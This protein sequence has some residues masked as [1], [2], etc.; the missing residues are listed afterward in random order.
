MDASNEDG[1]RR[2]SWWQTLPG[3][4]TAVA[5]V[6][7][8]VAGLII[9]LNGRS[10]GDETSQESPVNLSPLPPREGA[11]SGIGAAPAATTRATTAAR[12]L[13]ARAFP[14]GTTL[15]LSGGNLILDILSARLE[16]FNADMRAL[17]FKIRFTNNGKTFERSYYLTLR[18]V[19]DG[20]PRAPTEPPW[21][22]I[23]AQ[24]ARELEYV[25]EV[26]ANA[27]TT[28]LRVSKDPESME[29]PIDLA[30]AR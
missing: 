5:A 23:E 17:R 1:S 27:R 20:V 2:P 16:P 7:S 15:T 24:S 28:L 25:F 22:Q 19:A 29:L 26:P 9:A 18:L 4:L 21:E 13:D 14:E 8:A 11:T 10:A 6:I 3:V 12:T 30:A